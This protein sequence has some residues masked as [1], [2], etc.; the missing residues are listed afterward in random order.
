[1]EKQLLKLILENEIK[2]LIGHTPTDAEYKSAAQ[3]LRDNLSDKSD[4]SNVGL[5]LYDWRGDKLQQCDECGD[6][7]LRD[8]LEERFVGLSLKKF[9]SVDCIYDYYAAI[10]PPEISSHI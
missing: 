4:L 1:M 3:Y 7:F 10:E 9:C 6:Y 5:T 8:L 2:S